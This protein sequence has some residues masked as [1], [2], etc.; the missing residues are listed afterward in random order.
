[1][2]IRDRY[3]GFDGSKVNIIETG[4][5]LHG[6]SMS[7]K[8][9]SAQ[10]KKGLTAVAGLSV[11]KAIDYFDPQLTSALGPIGTPI[12]KIGVGALAAYYGLTKATGLMQDFLLFGGAELALSEVFKYILP[13]TMAR[14]PVPVAG[15]P[16]AIPLT[17]GGAQTFPGASS[18]IRAA[19]PFMRT[20]TTPTRLTAGYPQVA[21]ADGKYVQVRV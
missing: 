6:K 10:S 2:C 8:I 11:A 14:A 12:G 7:L 5:N 21:Q 9:T 15:A 3:T 4:N 18:T 19:A 20:F 1:M 17:P 16:V 13:A